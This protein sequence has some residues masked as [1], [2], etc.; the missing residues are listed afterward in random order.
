[1]AIFHFLLFQGID[2]KSIDFKA[3]GLRC[4]CGIVKG[5]ISKST[6][7]HLYVLD[8]EILDVVLFTGNTTRSSDARGT[9]QFQMKPT[10]SAD[11]AV[12]VGKGFVC[13]VYV[14]NWF[15]VYSFLN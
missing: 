5:P 15:M 13:L 8:H 12:L 2:I 11:Y 10:I 3:D 1:M 6:L 7:Y 9:M 4:N 14:D